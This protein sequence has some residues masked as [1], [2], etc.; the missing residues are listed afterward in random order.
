[1][2]F[3]DLCAHIA[4]TPDSELLLLGD[5]FDLTA[6]MPPA[7]G[8]SAFGKALGIPIDDKPARTLAEV[9]THIRENNPVA[10]D[11][12]ESL[13]DEARVTLV[14]GNHDR[15]LGEAGPREFDL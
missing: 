12:L 4:R 14:P 5:A 9:M 15:H 11:A 6:A 10:L 3:A 1:M 13:A 7:R 8:L 2:R